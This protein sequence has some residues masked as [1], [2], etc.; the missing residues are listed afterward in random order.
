[1]SALKSSSDNFNLSLSFQCWH[2]LI[3]FFIQ[4]EISQVS[5]MMSD[6]GLILHFFALCYK[7]L[8][9]I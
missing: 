7:M 8:D 3:N 1:M 4:V 6:S 9:H 2:V 5:S